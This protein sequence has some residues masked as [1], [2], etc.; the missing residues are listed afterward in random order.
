MIFR[1]RHDA[2]KQLAQSLLKYQ[3]DKETVVLG[4]ARGGVVVA[5][6]IASALHLPLAAFVVRK[7]GAPG[8]EEFALGAISETGDAKIHAD[9]VMMTSASAEYLKKIIE[10]EGKLAQERSQKY[11]GKK[12]P[13]ELKNK[14]IILVDDGIATGASIE[15]A[16]DS[17]KKA[18]AK[19]IILAVPVAAPDSFQRIKN[20]VDE[21][22]CLST[23]SPFMAVGNFYREFGQTSDDEVIALLSSIDKE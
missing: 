4:L 22:V 8:N 11:R 6:E 2:G 3:S 10:K 14:K 5:F 23:P 15:V 20:Q 13:P 16:I 18:G 19:K 12:P 17:L 1:D 9:S 21:A 7:I